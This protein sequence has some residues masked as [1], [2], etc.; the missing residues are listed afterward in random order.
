MGFPTAN[1]ACS[2]VLLSQ[3]KE[4]I[5]GAMTHIPSQGDSF[6]PSVA[7]IKDG[8]LEVHLLDLDLD[9]YDQHITVRL[10]Q[11]IRSPVPFISLDAMRIQIEKDIQII[12]YCKQN[13]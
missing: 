2:E 6:F 10:T 5:Y 13:T 3:F 9:L 1:I 12:Y 8:L 11:F 7:Y 4:G